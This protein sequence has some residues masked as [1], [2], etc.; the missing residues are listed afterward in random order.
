[1]TTTLVSFL[2]RAR[3]DPTTGC[4]LATYRFPDGTEQTTPFFG[5]ALRRVLA[6]DR[7]VLLGTRGSMWDL[8]ERAMCPRLA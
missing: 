6:P 4:R 2:G 5:L 3:Q 7:L 8:L 1:M